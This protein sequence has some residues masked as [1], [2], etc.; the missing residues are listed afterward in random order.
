MDIVSDRLEEERDKRTKKKKNGC[1][2][3][4]FFIFISFHFLRVSL[5]HG[6]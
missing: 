4:Y 6:S 3:H 5:E 1:L 2:F